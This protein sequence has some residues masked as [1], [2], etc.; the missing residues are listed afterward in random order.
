MQ[1]LS[2]PTPGPIK[3]NL[4][5]DN[6]E[7]TAS[8]DGDDILDADKVT[9]QEIEEEEVTAEELHLLQEDDLDG[10]AAALN[11]AET[12][13]LAD[14]DNFLHEDERENVFEKVATK[15]TRKDNS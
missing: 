14:S 7:Y 4:K 12:D 5:H 9:I 13:S 11:S 1:P 2:K 15:K 3:P 6:M 8:T 10:Q